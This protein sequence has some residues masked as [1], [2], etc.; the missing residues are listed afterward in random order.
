[1]GYFHLVK[2]AEECA[3]ENWSE[4]DES[5]LEEAQGCALGVVEAISRRVV[6]PPGEG[7]SHD[8]FAR[9]LRDDPL[10]AVDPTALL[11]L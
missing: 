10:A 11:S 5:L 2:A 3:Y 1:M 8:A 7:G 9:L 4:L 6:W